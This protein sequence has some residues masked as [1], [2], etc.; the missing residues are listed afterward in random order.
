LQAR[1]GIF[2]AGSGGVGQN[3]RALADALGVASEVGAELQ[4]QNIQQDI[5]EAQTDIQKGVTLGDDPSA[6]REATFMK[7]KAE[8]D[9]AA[10]QKRFDETLDSE[11]LDNLSAEELDLRISELVV[12][13]IGGADENDIY[14]NQYA[15]FAGEYRNQRIRDHQDRIALALNE[16]GQANLVAATE[17]RYDDHVTTGE[18]FDYQTFHTDAVNLS[19][20]GAEANDLM[21]TILA[22]QAINSADPEL[23]DNIPDEWVDGQRTFK[24]IPAFQE[25][26]RVARQR[27]ENAREAIN[28]ELIAQRKAEAERLLAALTIKA[29]EGDDVSLE[30]QALLE[31]G[32][33][34]AK[35]AR[36]IQTFS[37]GQ[38]GEIRTEAQRDLRLAQINTVIVGD[39]NALSAGDLLD[40]YRAGTFGPQDSPQARALHRQTVQDLQEAR[41]RARRGGPNANPIAKANRAELKLI[42]A[43]RK[44]VLGNV[45]GETAETIALTAE[46]MRRYDTEVAAGADPAVLRESL[47]EEFRNRK[48]SLSTGPGTL[49]IRDK[50]DGYERVNRGEVTPQDLRNSLEAQGIGVEE[51]ILDLENTNPELLRNIL[52]AY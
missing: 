45:L 49:S 22:T 13:Q 5:I 7:V 52:S 43:L 34:E 12:D 35:D 29:I 42:T 46:I 39:P 20:G 26:I 37:Q 28:K 14:A 40:E 51:V 50:N 24:H 48:Q 16:Q 10:D 1:A 2:G 33:I 6:A 38:R 17:A 36:P 15:A 44:D 25:R 32:A 41:D 27:A 18:P 21:M 30:L 47:T 11:D 9:W 4:K 31:D 3:A 8:A 23:I 19:P